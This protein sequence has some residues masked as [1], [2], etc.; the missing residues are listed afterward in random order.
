M[1]ELIE[2]PDTPPDVWWGD[3]RGQHRA[4]SDYDPTRDATD[5]SSGQ[6]NS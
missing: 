3:L 6:K 2:T 1:Y 5:C 4:E